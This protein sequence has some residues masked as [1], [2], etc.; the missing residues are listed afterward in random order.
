MGT[1]L[2]N[3]NDELREH[4]AA[5]AAQA[6]YN[7]AL[8]RMLLGTV[9]GFGAVMLDLKARALQLALKLATASGSARAGHRQHCHVSMCN[10]PQC[11]RNH[12]KLQLSYPVP[13]MLELRQCISW[14]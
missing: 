7:E 1:E 2:A 5:D 12:C 10:S 13:S 4:I 3:A 6:L 8:Q 14:L 11:Q 9:L